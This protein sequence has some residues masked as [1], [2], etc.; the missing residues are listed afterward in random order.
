VKIRIEEKSGFCFGVKRAIDLAEDALDR[1]ESVF[2]LGQIVH[3]ENEI[4]RLMQKGLIFI[5]HSQLSDL[6]DKTILIRAHGEPPATYEIAKKN[7]LKV[8]DGTC[9]IVLS[10]QKKI[11]ERYE[12]MDVLN[13]QIIIYGK[14]GHPE[15]IGLKG[16]AGD[17]PQVVRTKDDLKKLSLKRNVYL[18]SQTTMDTAGFMDIASELKSDESVISGMKS[19]INNTICNHISH[20]EPGL[21]KF[22]RANDII[23]FVAG[24]KSSNGRILFEICKSENSETYFISEKEE[25]NPYWFRGCTEVGIC[26][27]TSTPEWQLKEI[28]EII[29]SF[30][31]N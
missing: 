5:D 29:R 27:A 4:K 24:L 26:G 8:I 14:E 21:R 7:R 18:F 6:K 23:I 17:H 1:G 10:L 12:N 3:N 15:V 11:R 2:C 19:E 20:R 13:E 30:T 16:Q 25:L 9:P 22:A 31:E 28:A